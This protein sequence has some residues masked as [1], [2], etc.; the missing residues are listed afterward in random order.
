MGWAMIATLALTAGGFDHFIHEGRL[1]G[2]GGV[3]LT[4]VDCHTLDRAGGLRGAPDHATCFGSCHGDAPTKLR[5]RKKYT[6]TEARR[7]MCENCHAPDDLG[8]AERGE[9]RKLRAFYPPYTIESDYALNLSHEKHAAAGCETCHAVPPRHRTGKPHKRCAAC[10]AEPKT[11][12]TPPMTDCGACHRSAFGPAV[13]P[14]QKRGPLPVSKAFLHTSHLSRM[15]KRGARDCESCHAAVEKES[16]EKVP[17]PTMNSCES[18]HDGTRAFSTTETRCRSCHQEVKSARPERSART[19]FSHAQHGD[20]KQTFDCADCHRLDKEGRSLPTAP[21]HEPCA[22]EACHSSE[23]ASMKP[24]ICG[25]CHV[26][27]EPWRP[28]AWF[29]AKPARTEF[30]ATFSH[31]AH[32]EARPQCGACHGSAGARRPVR[33]GHASCV[34]EGCHDG[35]AKPALAECTGCH[36]R[37]SYAAR[38]DAAAKRRWSVRA[39]FRHDRHEDAC[40]DCHTAVAEASELDA[41]TPPAKQTCAPCHDGDSAFK[42]TGHRCTTCHGS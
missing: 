11:A 2:S 4:C 10:H 37:E 27:N 36:A 19:P 38:V 31:A 6:I 26:G 25:T 28:L 16:N 29:S 42:M 41:L 17:S 40:G 3:E 14:T 21:D 5:R 18:C 34:G 22:N 24:R 23:F 13:G 39:K 35:A 7:G 15:A 20:L 32:A 12:D 8:K 1:T 33:G 30:G 9:A